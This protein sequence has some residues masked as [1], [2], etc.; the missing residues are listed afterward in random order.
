MGAVRAST[1]WHVNAALRGRQAAIRGDYK[2][3]LD[4]S[5]LGKSYSEMYEYLNEK[6]ESVRVGREPHKRWKKRQ[7]MLHRLESYTRHLDTL[8]GIRQSFEIEGGRPSVDHNR[9]WAKRKA[10]KDK[11]E[12]LLKEWS[13]H[14]Q[15]STRLSHGKYFYRTEKSKLEFLASEQGSAQLRHKVAGLT[16]KS[17]IAKLISRSEDGEA[18][19]CHCGNVFLEGSIFCRI[20][21]EKRP[22]EVAKEKE[23]EG[24]VPQ[25]DRCVCGNA[26]LANSNF[27]R[28][29][30]KK[31]HMKSEL[32]PAILLGDTEVGSI[33]EKI[34]GNIAEKM[35]V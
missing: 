30:G 31:R 32:L 14:G 8:D 24:D 1:Q 15:T 28:I 4:A 25:V 19:H 9:T 27:C 7:K 12:D 21:G 3:D 13:H 34:V 16:K 17:V 18:E 23:L 20:C 10:Q 33:A 5:S 29:C 35:A 11:M 26:F 6:Y 2:Q 22:S